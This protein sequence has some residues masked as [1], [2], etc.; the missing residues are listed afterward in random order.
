MVQQLN[1][2]NPPKYVM[3]AV[4]ALSLYAIVS[5]LKT[6]C[7][8]IADT[9]L[10]VWHQHK[11]ICRVINNTFTISNSFRNIISLYLIRFLDHTY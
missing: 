10:E 8:V 5:L 6:I 2:V 1:Q 4:S 11:C 9:S 3:I 7:L